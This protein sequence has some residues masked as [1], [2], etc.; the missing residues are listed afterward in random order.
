MT[1]NSFSERRC[2][3]SYCPRRG[4]TLVELLV[5]IAI[6]GVLISLL[7]PAV[8]A[9][10]EAARRTQCASNLRQI[11]LAMHNFEN[12][13]RVLPAYGSLAGSNAGNFSIQARLLPFVEQE[14]LRNLLSFDV[15]LTIGCCPGDLHPRFIEPARTVIKLFR[16]PSDGN[17]DLFQIRTGTSGGA[18]GRLD[19]YAGT[20]YHVNLGSALGTNY[21]AR[22]PTDGIAW[23]NSRVTFADIL[24]GTSH[25]AAFGESLLGVPHDPPPAAPQ[26]DYA[27]KRTMMNI[28]C[29]WI[30]NTAPPQ[31]PGLVGYVV[32]WDPVT[33]YQ[34]SL[35]SPLFRGWTGARGAGW[36][37]GREYW[38]GY[39]HYLPP[40]SNIPDMQ[41][42]G[43]GVLGARSN[44]PGGVNIGFCDG[45]L[46]FIRDTID[47]A[48]WR[49]LATRAGGEVANVE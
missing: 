2:F 22:L 20:N 10:R 26:T 3:P 27:R 40:N 28:R 18:T 33:Y 11:V 30:S 6:I 45:S 7:L 34:M 46:R 37:S 31:V 32:P 13:Y 24:D 39:H 23:N 36:I 41:T 8:Q 43:N 4:F 15:P 21:D 19:L 5:V 38:T 16:C 35:S 44:H 29:Q 1:Q 47:L 17:T 42:C 14:N 9:A 48:V 12:T 49:A 25:T